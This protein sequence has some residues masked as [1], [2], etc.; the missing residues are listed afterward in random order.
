[1]TEERLLYLFT[2]MRNMLIE[3]GKYE[4]M[5]SRVVDSV[6]N[7]YFFNN[8]KVISV[9]SDS[10]YIP[11]DKILLNSENYLRNTFV[12]PKISD[13]KLLFYHI[14]SPKSLILNE[15]CEL[16]PSEDCFAVDI[17]SIDT[18]LI[19]GE[20][21]DF[22]YNRLSSEPELFNRVINAA[23]DAV[24]IGVCLECQVYKKP[25]PVLNPKVEALLTESG[26]FH[27]IEIGD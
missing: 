21:F 17:S 20:A 26:L 2:K 8:N 22:Q 15:N 4:K 16:I 23:E 18:I 6:E 14:D 7:S 3:K 11:L 13:G 24:K 10:K 5:F 27:H 12:F 9:F 25:L 19:P 1:M